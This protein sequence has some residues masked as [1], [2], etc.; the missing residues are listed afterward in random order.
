MKNIFLI[1]LIILSNSL[2]AQNDIDSSYHSCKACIKEA[3]AKE[4]SRLNAQDWKDKQNSSTDFFDDVGSG[5]GTTGKSYYQGIA[6]P[7][8]IGQIVGWFEDL[9]GHDPLA[10]V[11]GSV[12]IGS[13][14]A[15]YNVSK[16]KKK[17][18]IHTCGKTFS[19]QTC[20]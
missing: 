6:K 12:V 18:Y 11:V 15:E 16:N 8:L 5:L 10:G 17:K 19:S 9:F 7:L 14:A 20:H 3:K 1:I 4:K 2:F 13:G